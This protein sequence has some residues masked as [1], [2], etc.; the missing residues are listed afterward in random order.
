MRVSSLFCRGYEQFQSCAASKRTKNSPSYGTHGGLPYRAKAGP[1]PWE[2]W[3][4]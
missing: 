4:T 2:W 1:I 3:S